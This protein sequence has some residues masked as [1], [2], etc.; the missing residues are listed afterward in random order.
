MRNKVLAKIK[1]STVYLMYSLRDYSVMCILCIVLAI[2]FLGFPLSLQYVHARKLDSLY[3]V[4]VV[5]IA[6]CSF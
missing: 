2:L 4:L 5:D 6:V 1:H 3:K